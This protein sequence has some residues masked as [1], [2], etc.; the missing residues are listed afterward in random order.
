VTTKPGPF[1]GRHHT[2]DTKARMS[3]RKDGR[4]MAVVALDAEG[5]I[6]H[7]FESKSAAER[8]GFYRQN[9]V[10]CTAGRQLTHR[11]LRWLN[12]SDFEKAGRT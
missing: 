12:Y 9:I 3:Q 11:G 2:P 10:H 6:V 7:Y 1:T 5:H 8:A 4:K